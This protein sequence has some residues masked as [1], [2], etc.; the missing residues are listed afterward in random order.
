MILALDV[1]VGVVFAGAVVAVA[2]RRSVER[3]E[4]LE[5]VVVVADAGLARRR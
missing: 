3:G 1:G 4:A 5:P 2:L